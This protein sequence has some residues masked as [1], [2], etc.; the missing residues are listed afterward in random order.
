VEDPAARGHPLHVA[1]SER[2]LVAEAVGVRDVAGENVGDGLDAAMRVPRESRA[3]VGGRL[4]AE[5]VEEE[6]RVEVGGVAEAK[7]A[8]QLDA[9]S[10]DVGVAWMMRLTAL[11]DIM[12]STIH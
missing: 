7:G 11:T 6:K 1:G 9:G 3:V 12:Y 8:A 4:V 2:P 5:V 10:F